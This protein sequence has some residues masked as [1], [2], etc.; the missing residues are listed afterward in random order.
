MT[1]L[2]RL[3]VYSL[4]ET[5][6]AADGAINNFI[7][8]GIRHDEMEEIRRFLLDEIGAIDQRLDDCPG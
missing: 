4:R 8:I 7:V 1:I 5:H 2:D 6:S 3:E